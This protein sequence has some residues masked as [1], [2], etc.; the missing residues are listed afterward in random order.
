MVPPVKKR[1]L[2]T[3]VPVVLSVVVPPVMAAPPA[4]ANVPLSM[5]LLLIWVPPAAPAPIDE[6]FV[7]VR[8]PPEKARTGPTPGLWGP[9]SVPLPLRVRLP[10][11]TLTVPLLLKV[12]TIVVDVPFD[13]VSVLLLVNVPRPLIGPSA[14][15]VN[16]PL[17]VN[18]TPLPMAKA[19]AG[20]EKFA[21]LARFAPRSIWPLVPR[22]LR[23]PP[24][25][26]AGTFSEPKSQLNVP[27][28]ESGPVPASVAPPS[29]RLV[30]EVELASVIVPPRK[31]RKPVPLPV[32]LV[33]V[34]LP[35]KSMV[36][37]LVVEN[38]PVCDAPPV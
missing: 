16:A 10:V 15:M 6:G 20:E 38:V 9:G 31:S 36:P 2:M 7:S 22:R 17:F 19:F 3:A 21:P 8:V 1:P 18:V 26:V 30:S 29:L 25:F 27:P 34:L 35:L 4:G 33:K 13:L 14:V 28:K 5:K 11:L 37:G 12:Q 23:V 24:P 32:T